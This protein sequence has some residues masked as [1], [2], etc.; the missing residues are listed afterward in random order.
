M[1]SS[2]DPRSVAIGRAVKGAITTA[3]L[4]LLDVSERTGI[5]TPT[6]SRRVNGSL[7]FTFPELCQIAELCG[8]RASDLAVA[9]ERVIS[10][11][12]A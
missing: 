9:A 6:L 12:A 2:F 11:D 3:G 5:T 4:T 1:S 7:P 10:K 8:I